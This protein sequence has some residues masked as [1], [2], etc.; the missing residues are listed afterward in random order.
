MPNHWY[1][2]YYY[3]FAGTNGFAETYGVGSRCVLHGGEW[4]AGLIKVTPFGAGCY[5]VFLKELLL[6]IL[7][8]VAVTS[9]TPA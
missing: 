5:Q 6:P 7:L 2:A 4:T 3:F 8:V 9:S 1:F